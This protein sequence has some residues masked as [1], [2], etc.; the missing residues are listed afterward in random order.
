[1]DSSLVHFIKVMGEYI[2]D[3]GKKVVNDEKM[4]QSADQFT[5]VII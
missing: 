3:E 5:E 1:V 2:K 4:L